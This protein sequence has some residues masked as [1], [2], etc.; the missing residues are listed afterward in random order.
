MQKISTRKG[1]RVCEDAV[2]AGTVKPSICSWICLI[3]RWPALGFVEKRADRD[4]TGSRLNIFLVS[5]EL[6]MIPAH[7]DNIPQRHAAEF[8]APYSFTS[9]V[10][11]G[12]NAA[13]IFTFSVFFKFSAGILVSAATSAT[14]QAFF[15]PVPFLG[16]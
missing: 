11:T 1:S 13:R 4:L 3:T 6:I 15:F 10:P 5:T 12:I 7:M 14:T 2:T 8:L 16:G 9:A